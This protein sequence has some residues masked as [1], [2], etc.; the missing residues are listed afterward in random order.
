MD[1]TGMNKRTTQQLMRAFGK[2]SS[3]L[4]L[5]ERNTSSMKTTLSILE[6][7]PRKPKGLNIRLKKLYSPR[8]HKRTIPNCFRW[9]ISSKILCLSAHTEDMIAGSLFI[10]YFKYKAFYSS[11]RSYLR[12]DSIFLCLWLVVLVSASWHSCSFV[13]WQEQIFQM[14]F[15][16]LRWLPLRGS[17]IKKTY[18]FAKQLCLT[19][20]TLR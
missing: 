10:S 14:F 11:G 9:D 13:P 4:S 20:L 19:V 15:L 5:L 8:S 1:H 17:Y 2:T 7:Q 3:P 12:N 18:F 16:K 6:V